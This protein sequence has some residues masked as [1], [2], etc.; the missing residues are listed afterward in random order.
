MNE[1]SPE[2]EF[3]FFPKDREKV[4]ENLRKYAVE[5]QKKTL[6][7]AIACRKEDNPGFQNMD[8]IRVRDEWEI[9]KVT[10]KYFFVE[11]KELDHALEK[12]FS[13]SNF[14]TAA[15][16]LRHIWLFISVE[17]EKYRTQWELEWCEIVLDENPWLEPYFEIEWPSLEKIQEVCEKIQCEWETK[18]DGGTRI[19]YVEKYG[20]HA[21][22]VRKITFAE[23]PFT[24]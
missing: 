12:E 13:V 10:M 23:N 2:I 21:R 18:R 19:L 24:L 4:L 5:K 20:E 9:T 17:S 14:E 16:M 15:N 7:R 8:I 11:D 3:K 1:Y 6:M 22:T